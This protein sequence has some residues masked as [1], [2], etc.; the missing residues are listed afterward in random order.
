M[1]TKYSFVF[2]TNAIISAFLLPD[3]VSKKAFN[4][5]FPEGLLLASVETF[6]EF[7]DVILRSRLDKYAPEIDRRQFMRTPK[8]QLVLKNPTVRILDCR[9][10]QDNKF[11]ELAESANAN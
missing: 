1:K 2:D 3:S 4:K 11:F 9:D 5:G 10:P 8:M 7:S 6:D